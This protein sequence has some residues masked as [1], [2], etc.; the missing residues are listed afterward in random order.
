MG[1]LT[2]WQLTTLMGVEDLNWLDRRTALARLL[3]SAF[4]ACFSSPSAASDGA[5][6]GAG[7]LGA[8]PSTEAAEAAAWWA[9]V[10]D[11]ADEAEAACTTRSDR[12]RSRDCS[13]GIKLQLGY[14]RIESSRVVQTAE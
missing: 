5:S 8:E 2:E 9:G 11:E 14:C 7:L 1:V 3:L 6:E 10:A 12:L 13:R 4:I